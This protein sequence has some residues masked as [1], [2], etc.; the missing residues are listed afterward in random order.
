VRSCVVNYGEGRNERGQ[1]CNIL[2]VICDRR[3]HTDACIMGLLALMN[4]RNY[5]HDSTPC[6]CPLFALE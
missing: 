5:A 4:N 3:T 2:L 6:T 1:I